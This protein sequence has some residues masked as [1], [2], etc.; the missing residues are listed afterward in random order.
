MG[1]Y[2][3]RVHG[4]S[5][6]SLQF[7][8]N[9]TSGNNFVTF[10]SNGQ[11][12]VKCNGIYLYLGGYGTSVT[13]FSIH[14]IIPNNNPPEYKCIYYYPLK[15][16]TEPITIF[17]VPV[18]SQLMPKLHRPVPSSSD[19]SVSYNPDNNRP[20]CQVQVTANSPGGS[21]TGNSVPEDGGIY[22]GTN[23]GSLNVGSLSGLGDLV[24]TRTCIPPQD[25]YDHHHANDDGC[26]CNGNLLIFDKLDLTY[27]SIASSEVSWVQPGSSTITTS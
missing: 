25:T 2:S 1:S 5:T 9:E 8:T 3:S 16:K 11:E 26:Q 14:M 10:D 18:L 6:V 7:I 13:T 20:D 17:T 23:N 22:P 15:G 12:Y 27:T 24:M 4:S 19:I 21:A